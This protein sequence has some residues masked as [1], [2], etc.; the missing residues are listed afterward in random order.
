MTDSHVMKP[1]H[2]P[3]PFSAAEI[4]A[5]CPSGR[6]VVT[7]ISD[8]TDETAT[9]VT[10]FRD[11]DEHGAIFVTAAGSHRVRWED[12]QGHASFPAADTT[13]TAETIETPLGELTCMLYTVTRPTETHR[14]WFAHEHPGMPI[15]TEV[16][17]EGQIVSTTEVIEN[18]IE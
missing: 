14:F 18:T 5:G 8:E 12:L 1:G 10:V 15:R 7:R 4:R 13:I 9:T 6:R 3:T 17:R 16:S 2:A 11:V